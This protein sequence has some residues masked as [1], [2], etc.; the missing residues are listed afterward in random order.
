[1]TYSL[2]SGDLVRT[3]VKGLTGPFARSCLSLLLVIGAVDTV[4]RDCSHT[5]VCKRRHTALEAR[6]T[7]Y[8]D[9]ATGEGGQ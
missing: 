1:M 9:V 3:L 6:R 7:N 4:I 5:F 2:V 8:F